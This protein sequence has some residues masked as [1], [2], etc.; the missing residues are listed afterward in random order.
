MFKDIL[1]PE[2]FIG[3]APSQVSDYLENTVRPLIKELSSQVKEASEDEI[4]V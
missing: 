2:L 1:N 3:R 4:R